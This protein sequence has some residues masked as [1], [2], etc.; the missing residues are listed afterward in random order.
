[1]PCFCYAKK[2]AWYLWTDKKTQEPYILF[3]NGNEIEH[4][5]LEQG[6]RSKMKILR[7]K[8]N[9]DIPRD[10]ILSVIAASIQLRVK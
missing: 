6:T 3:V 10:L 5:M 1:M 2:P 8:P 4:P 7:V 9:E